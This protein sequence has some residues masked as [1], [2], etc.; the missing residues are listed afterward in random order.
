MHTINTLSFHTIYNIYKV[1]GYT[2]EPPSLFMKV[3]TFVLLKILLEK[4]INITLVFVC[5][6][7]ALGILEITK[8]SNGFIKNSIAFK[9]ASTI[10]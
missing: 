8:H 3:Y 6:R 2:D 9:V 7:T 4:F 1:G 10:L 5:T